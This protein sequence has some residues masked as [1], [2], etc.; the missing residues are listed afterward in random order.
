VDIM[1]RERDGVLSVEVRDDGQGM[2]SHQVEQPTLGLIGVWERVQSL[3]GAVSIETRPG[4]GT[5]VRVVL[6][7][8][9]SALLSS[10]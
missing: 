4:L 5:Q 1:L 3:G 9:T 10:D 8:T 2:A 7:A 6:P